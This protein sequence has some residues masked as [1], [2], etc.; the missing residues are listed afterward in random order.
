MNLDVQDLKDN[1]YNELISFCQK[2]KK[3]ILLTSRINLRIKEKLPCLNCNLNLGFFAKHLNF[4]NHD[5]IEFEN[6]EVDQ[7][8]DQVTVLTRKYYKYKSKYIK[9]KSETSSSFN[10][11]TTSLTNMQSIDNVDV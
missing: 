4:N 2:N 6:T 10:N 5:K 7:L 9:V 1:K 3:L 11:N 8:K